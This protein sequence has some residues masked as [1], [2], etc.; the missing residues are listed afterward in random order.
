MEDLLTIL[1]MP[2]NKFGGVINLFTVYL[3]PDRNNDDGLKMK[4]IMHQ[5]LGMRAEFHVYRLMLV[6]TQLELHLS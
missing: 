4:T 3:P 6:I 5:N 1:T 2:P